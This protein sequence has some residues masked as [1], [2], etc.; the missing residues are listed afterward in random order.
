MKP[1]SSNSYDNE[2]AN[3]LTGGPYKIPVKIVKLSTC[4]SNSVKHASVR[5]IYKKGERTGIQNYR[6]VSILNRFWKM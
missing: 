4:F 5:P 3:L 2:P 1:C 6:P